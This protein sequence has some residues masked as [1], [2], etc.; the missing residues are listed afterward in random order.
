MRIYV[1]VQRYW[2]TATNT[3]LT[4]TELTSTELV[5]RDIE[6]MIRSYEL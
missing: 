5:M 4:N 1:L 2:Y 3:E 6:K